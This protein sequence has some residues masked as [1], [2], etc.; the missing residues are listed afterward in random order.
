MLGAKGELEGAWPELVP[1]PS[2]STARTL[3]RKPRTQYC[4]CQAGISRRYEL[5]AGGAL[6]R[7][8]R[9]RSKRPPLMA[10]DRGSSVSG[11]S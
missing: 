8:I 9:F 11:F 1:F 7:S 2:D 10:L 5:G 4:P 3:N 6:V